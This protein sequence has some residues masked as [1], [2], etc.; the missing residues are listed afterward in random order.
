MSAVA[1]PEPDDLGELAMPE[2]RQRREHLQEVEYGYSYARRVVQGRLDTLLAELDRRGTAKENDSPL[3]AMPETLGNKIQGNGLPRPT[4]GLEPPDW[5]DELLVECD[6][7]VSPDA[8]A[9]LHD[10]DAR[11]LGEIASRVAAIENELS[12]TRTALHR[13][14]DRVQAELISRYQEGAG[15]EDL[16]K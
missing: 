10:L 13:R 7:A 8:L 2:L 12:E 3:Q 15:V 1:Q 6:R 14:I 9:H 5:A 4:R 16:L 11:T